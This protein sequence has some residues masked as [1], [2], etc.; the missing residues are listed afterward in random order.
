[1][2]AL[3][4]RAAL[5]DGATVQL[6]SATDG[7]GLDE[8]RRALKALERELAGAAREGAERADGSAAND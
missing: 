3:R 4:T 6:F 8:A 2:P 5:G 1:M 7:Q